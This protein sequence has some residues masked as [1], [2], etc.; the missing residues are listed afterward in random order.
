[1]RNS[2]IQGSLSTQD[3]VY[4]SALSIVTRMGNEKIKTSFIDDAKSVQIRR[5][6]HE[7]FMLAKQLPQLLIKSRDEHDMPYIF[8][9]QLTTKLGGQ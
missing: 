9:D 6:P 1:M 3:A 2:E 8:E 5:N 7:M 4:F